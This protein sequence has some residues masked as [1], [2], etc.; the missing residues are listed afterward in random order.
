MVSVVKIRCVNQGTALKA[1]C[2]AN[3]LIL[4]DFLSILSILALLF[5][6]R[7]SAAFILL[8]CFGVYHLGY[9]AV[10]FLMPMAI[11]QHWEKQI[12]ENEDSDLTGR[13]V[14]VPF[15]MP[16]GQDQ[17]EFQPVNFP[18]EIEGKLVRV[19]KQRYY[20]DHLEVIVVH[21]ELQTNL[22]EQVKN[23]LFALGADSGDAEAPPL[24]KL[25]LKS[26]A[27]NFVSY[28]LELEFGPSRSE[29]PVGHSTPFLLGMP[30]GIKDIFLPPP[31]QSLLS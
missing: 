28:T 2:L 8:S 24:Q 27:K 20:D 13:L 10:Q 6:M 7:K 4:S 9:F 21:D 25:L 3:Q 17:E 18:I 11:H 5:V 16:Y 29:I 12:W 30:T 23:W 14:R 31:R 22:K 1:I 26:F 15:P 19:I